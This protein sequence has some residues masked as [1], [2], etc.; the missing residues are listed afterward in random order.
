MNKVTW[1]RWNNL[2]NCENHGANSKGCNECAFV[3]FAECPLTIEAET[4]TLMEWAYKQGQAN[5]GEPFETM[6]PLSDVKAAFE[7]YKIANS[8][9]GLHNA[10]QQFEEYL[11]SLDGSK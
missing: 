8:Q 10:M 7:A 4:Q 6:V 1:E 2:R 3:D 9:I 5:P 11:N